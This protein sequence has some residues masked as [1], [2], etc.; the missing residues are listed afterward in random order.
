MRI[1]FLGD[2]ALFGNYSVNSNTELQSRLA[3]I[4]SYLKQF[5]LVVG[6][7]ESPFS[8]KKKTKGAKSAYV[9]TDVENVDILKE[10]HID[11]VTLANNH[12]FDYG[13]E[14][15]E[16]TM[17]ILKEANIDWFGVDG[18][19]VEIIKGENRLVFSGYCCYSTNPIY[20]A[21]NNG[22]KGVNPYNIKNVID[23]LKSAKIKGYF[24]IIANHAGVEHVNYPSIDHVRAARNLAD[25]C[26]YLYYG[27]HP[28]VIQG[29][30]EYNGSL[31]AHS[32]GNFCFDDVYANPF[33]RE[34]LIKLSEQNRTGLI[35]E[36]TF[37]NNQ[38]LNWR[39]Q[40]VYIGH[41]GVITL[42]ADDGRLEEYNNNLIYCEDS[43]EEYSSN[44]EAILKARIIQR[45]SMRNIS[46]FLKRLRLRYIKLLLDMR[47]NAKQYDRNIKKYLYNSEN[48]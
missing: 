26:P 35:L 43:P 28:H 16:T 37:E 30:E 25:V 32:L 41:D 39:E 42:L 12:M 5:D 48:Y 20:V 18:K 31:I 46:W 45:K 13:V 8:V 15:Y 24:P 4:S 14:G 11:I 19:K 1:A 2:I 17:R 38:I 27:H 44:R 34:P 21:K 10:L 36:V 47:E 29:I 22:D 9:C 3:N 40:M 23:D 7:L 33:D 6:N